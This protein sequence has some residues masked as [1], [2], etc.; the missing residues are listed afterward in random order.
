[1]IKAV[2]FD[3]GGTLVKTIEI[4][5]IYRRILKQ[6]EVDVTAEEISEA[7]KANEEKARHYIKAQLETGYQYWYDWNRTVLESLGYGERSEYL[8]RM[9]SDHWWDYADLELYPDVMETIDAL[10]EKGVRVGI[11][12]NGF[13]YDYIEIL[14]MLGLS[15]FFDI[16]MGPDSCGYGKPDKRIFQYAL[17]ELDLEPNEVI[18]VGNDYEKDYVGAGEAGMVSLLI[19]R[20]QEIDGDA[21]VIQSLIEILDN[22]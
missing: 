11:L 22:L 20:G 14:K 3:L 1:M 13:K 6:F 8:G 10:R 9:I 12:T 15:N 21:S 18:Y 19:D 4:P 2:L 5:E 7:H 16:V 17:D